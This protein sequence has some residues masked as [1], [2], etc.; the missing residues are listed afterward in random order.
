[1]RGT[2]GSLDWMLT[3]FTRDTPGVDLAVVLSADGLRLATSPGVSE[4]LGD[5]IAAA[6]AG[7]D[8]LARG[9]ARLLGDGKLTQSILEMEAGYLFISAIDRGATLVVHAAR[10]CDMGLVGYEMAMLA[11]R[12]G[13]ALTPG[14]RTGI[15]R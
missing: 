11:S 14:P 13:H 15:P 7:L 10:G 1:M 8:S 6:A 3:E 5:Q 12:A 4:D 2:V 9:A